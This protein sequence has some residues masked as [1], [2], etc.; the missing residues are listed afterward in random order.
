MEIKTFKKGT[1]RLALLAIQQAI[2]NLK[3]Q[4]TNLN[5]SS[6][7]KSKQVL[8]NF[9]S[10]FEVIATEE[11]GFT[12]FNLKLKEGLLDKLIIQSEKKEIQLFVHHHSFINGTSYS[13]VYWLPTQSWN[14]SLF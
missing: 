2:P 11:A 9:N 8:V 4:P 14:L 1:A 3:I 12:N 13:S 7:I 10:E 6:F 5:Y